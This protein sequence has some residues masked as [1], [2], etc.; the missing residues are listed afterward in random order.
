MSISL[1]LAAA[2]LPM[3]HLSEQAERLGM[4]DSPEAY[5]AVCAFGETGL[6]KKAP[7]EVEALSQDE[8][9][10]Y[11]AMASTMMMSCAGMA[12]AIGETIGA[13]RDYTTRS[14]VKMCAGVTV[15]QLL[16]EARKL[17]KEQPDLVH[18][19]GMTTARFLLLSMQRIDNCE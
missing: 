4:L 18:M 16:A 10:Q 7:P 3:P 19:E 5:L 15:P 1:L 2:L 12:R 9:D 11:Y 17:A 6:S 14:G 8:R 13:A